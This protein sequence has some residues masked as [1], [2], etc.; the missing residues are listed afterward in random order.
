MA[1]DAENKCDAEIASHNESR[2]VDDEDFFLA[3]LATLA[4]D[5]AASDVFDEKC[6]RRASSRRRRSAGETW[7]V[8]R[9][10]IPPSDG[11]DGA[12]RPSGRSD[13][14]DRR[15]VSD[16]DDDD[17][18]F[19]TSA[20]LGAYTRRSR[21]LQ[22]RSI[23]GKSSKAAGGADLGRVD[24]SYGDIS[25][26]SPRE[27]PDC[28][29]RGAGGG[30]DGLSDVESSLAAATRRRPDRRG[31]DSRKRE[32]RHP[33]YLGESWRAFTCAPVAFEGGM[34][35]EECDELY[36]GTRRYSYDIDGDDDDL[37]PGEQDGTTTTTRPTGTAKAAAADD[38]SSVGTASTASMRSAWSDLSESSSSS[39]AG[40]D[41]GA[42]AG[43]R[44][45]SRRFAV[46][47]SP[48][49][50]IRTVHPLSAY[51]RSVREC[52]W[53]ARNQREWERQK[54]AARREREHDGEDWRLA[55]EEEGFVRCERTGRRVHP[56]HVARKTRHR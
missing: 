11:A 32:D 30:D 13:R 56:V 37:P 48:I 25:R 4:S 6:E 51:P 40:D 2:G 45:P 24:I 28:A 23:S 20:G 53:Y 1:L 5:S 41:E 47:F 9:C 43:G 16:D 8:R 19:L 3:S 54:R 18:S 29:R 17:D 44:A 35:L 21:L 36:N 46:S 50:K 42:P 12:S 33:L 55:T 52:L 34:S 7:K 39:A 38:E 14:G 49:V 26:S 15:P 31:L 22:G 27:F 10:S